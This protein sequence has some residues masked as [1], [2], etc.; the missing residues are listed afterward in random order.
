MG[1]DLSKIRNRVNEMA[2]QNESKG[3]GSSGEKLQFWK[4]ELGDN[5][6][7]I[8]PYDDGNGQPF[9]EVGY[10]NAK[11]LN[12]WRTVAPFQFG[13]GDPVHEVM[14]ELRKE[15]Q[16]DE[17]WNLMKQLRVKASFYAPVLVRGQ[18]DKGVQ[19]WEMSQRVV[20]TI[21][22]LL[23]NEDYAEENIFDI[24][25]GYDFTVTAK[26]SGREFNGHMIKD[27]TIIPKR[28]PS[29]ALKTKKAC[30]ELV[31]AVPDFKAHFEGKCMSEEK[32]RGK[33]DNFLNPDN[34][35]VDDEGTTKTEDVTETEEGREA[36]SK[37]AD[38][39]AGL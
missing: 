26:D 12:E 24:H 38:A 13:K 17:V 28:H 10:Y 6:V 21:Y 2:R 1:Y 5:I 36:T 33:V 11:A 8:L 25:E 22:E 32:L 3:S 30:D 29:T 23:V 18:E 9:Q 14:Q 35:S 7:R 34:G 15:R 39:F 31:K 37:I 4:P 20:Q 16:S 19:V 27:I